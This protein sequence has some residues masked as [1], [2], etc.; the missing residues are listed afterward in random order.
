MFGTDYVQL[1]DLAIINHLGER[2]D[3]DIR[4]SIFELIKME[5]I[6]D[7]NRVAFECRGHRLEGSS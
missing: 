7:L 1:L 2:Y 5:A 3:I 4:N 6:S